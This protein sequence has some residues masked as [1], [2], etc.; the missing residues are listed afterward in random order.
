MFKKMLLSLILVSLLI[1]VNAPIVSAAGT[2]DNTP[3]DSTFCFSYWNIDNIYAMT[4]DGRQLIFEFPTDF[5][6]KT[7]ITTESVVLQSTTGSHS[8]ELKFSINELDGIEYMVVTIMN[9]QEDRYY[10]HI[11]FNMINSV[12]S[13]SNDLA[14]SVR[15]ELSVPYFV[16]YDANDNDVTSSVVT[17]YNAQYSCVMP[18]PRE[19]G[20]VGFNTTTGTYSGLTSDVVAYNT[21]YNFGMQQSQLDHIIQA[22]R[23]EGY[24]SAQI[25][26]YIDLCTVAIDTSYYDIMNTT[27]DIYL[28]IGRCYSSA[29]YNVGSVRVSL[30]YDIYANDDPFPSY[31]DT[32]IDYGLDEIT[33]FFSTIVGGVF[34]MQIFPG[35]YIGGIAFAFFGIL[36]VKA[37]IN[38]F[39]GG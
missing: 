6:Y 9:N 4:N 8:I 30:W 19:D 17:S 10:T 32:D 2:D 36:F 35:I 12:L 15:P 22:F 13:V 27:T 37:C 29:G 20:S 21:L 11:E 3:Q 7:Q 26:P 5:F 34:A 24:P 28:P 39:A 33:S 1:L 18:N 25:I 38:F 23:D 31:P 16:I 14:Y